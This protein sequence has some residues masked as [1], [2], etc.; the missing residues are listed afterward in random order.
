MA[1]S[2]IGFDLKSLEVFAAIVEAGGMTAAGQRLGMTQSSVSQS[3]ANLEAQLHVQL[4]DRSQRPPMLTP[5]GR[6]FY[7]QADRLLG[8]ARRVS[9]EFRRQEATPLKHVRIALVDSL[10]ISVGKELVAAIKRRTAHWS[11]VTGQSHQHAD[12]LLNRRVDIILSDDAVPNHPELF[13]R[14]LL[15]EPFIL[16]LP[17]DFKGPVSSLRT[18]AAA[19]DFIR[20]NPST[21]IGRTIENKLQEWSIHPPLRMELD[22]SYAILQMVKAGLGWALT[23]PLC[24]LQGGIK[25]G[26]VQCLPVPEGEFV[27]ELTLLAR[28]GELG[29]LPELLADDS[30]ALMQER[31][32]PVL[33]SAAPWLLPRIVLGDVPR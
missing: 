29:N 2:P 16:V 5:L 3:I 32:L 10:A 23:T 30:I 9:L 22:N 28:N 27:R 24:L 6:K 17:L 18:L 13:R 20:Y 33:A 1:A 25:T 4:L 31:Y 8:D 14:R 26:E 12:A 19:L 7:E 21:V 11:M 15:R